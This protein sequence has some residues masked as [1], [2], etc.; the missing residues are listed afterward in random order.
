MS[1]KKHKQDL[2]ELK[3][4]EDVDDIEEEDD[5]DEDPE[6]RNY[7]AK[8]ASSATKDFVAFLWPYLKAYSG[9]TL[10]LSIFLFM[11][12][13]FNTAFPLA[14]KFLIDDALI[15]QNYR[16]L[17]IVLIVL[18]VS[19]LLIS[20]S[21]TIHD[22]IYAKL[23][24]AL[25]RDI[26]QKIFKHLQDLSMRF[27]SHAQVG[28][29]L[30]YF[31][32]DLSVIENA[33]TN[34]IAWAVLPLLEVFGNI[35]LLFF[36]DYRLASLAV[37]IA[38]LVLIGPRLF[39]LRAV[40]KSYL[41]KDEEASIMAL[42]QENVSSQQVVKAFSL[43]NLSSNWFQERNKQ[44]CDSSFKVFFF[45][46]MVERSASTLAIILHCAVVGIGAYLTFHK[47]MTIGKLVTF[48]SAFLSL[49][50]GI[51]YATQFVPSL[52]QAAGAIKR[53]NHL[54]SISP[55]VKDSPNAVELTRPAKDIVFKNVSFSYDEKQKPLNKVNFTIPTGS[56]VSF[57]GASGAGKSTIINLLL[58]FYEPIAGEILIDGQNIS[59]VSQ[60]SLRKHIGVVFQENLLFNIS[61]RENI[62]L[63]LP[64]AT[65]EEVE[66]AARLA[67]IHDFIAS[68]PEG[69]DTIAG[70]RGNLLS[71]GQRQR[72]AI[73]RAII[74]NPAILI[75]D[76]AT[77][78]LDP[79]TE[80]AILATLKKLATGR[81]I[82]SITHR[83]K[84]I[85]DAD[86]LFKIEK[87]TVKSQEHKLAFA[88]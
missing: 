46:A 61:L 33:N 49:S 45:S 43:E 66:K 80:T 20:I 38:P 9:Q 39:S 3:V 44:L 68:L 77:S 88:H 1:A 85:N 52:V 22:Y 24:A 47:Q 51:T 18:A 72:I 31:S 17:V 42:T 15:D 4:L 27:Y 70:E 56:Y 25:M 58:R 34:V 48:E 10:L 21:G 23:S 86:F 36:L 65:D 64:E 57:V 30:S 53:L 81:T 71:G 69:Y 13:V 12:M 59:Q 11:E 78:A 28:N 26:R 87:G 5:D 76:E 74:R 54:L 35:V 14:L 50:Y 55:E 8:E 67:E 60:S 40:E 16:I 32:N 6:E 84:S 19:G 75:L 29:I 63:G 2:E 82:I 37:L 41:K 73:A 79:A 62:R 83:L 7:S